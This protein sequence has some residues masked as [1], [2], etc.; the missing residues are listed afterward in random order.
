LFAG[1]FNDTYEV[2][3]PQAPILVRAQVAGSFV[4][5]RPLNIEQIARTT[6]ELYSAEA[7]HIW[8]T[9]V[10]STIVGGR[11]QLG[12]FRVRNLH[13]NPADLAGIFPD[14]PVPQ[15]LD[16][17]FERWSVYGYQSWQVFEPLLLVGGVSYDWL[18]FPENFRS[19]PM[20]DRQEEVERVLPK[21]GLIWTPAKYTTVRG[22]Y[23]RSLAGASLD[24]SIRLEPTQVAGFNQA[25]RSIIPE[26]VAGANAGARFETYDVSLEQRIGTRTYLGMDGEILYSKVPR[27]V[28]AYTLDTDV[29]DF[30]F[31]TGLRERLGFRER[32]LAFTIDQLLGNE[33][34]LGGRYRLSQAQLNGR[35]PEVT[36]TTTVFP[37]FIARPRVEAVL[38]QLNLHTIY[39]HPSGCFAQFQAHWSFQRNHGDT[40]ARPGDDFWHFD[41]F[42]G[43]RFPRRQ[44]QITVGVLN[45]ADRDYRLGPLNA[46]SERPRER[47]F[48]ARLQLNF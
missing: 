31:P 15:A 26:S 4:A 22:A 19:G 9:P 23:T 1:R 28:G 25:F 27:R 20:S 46:S 34:T 37:P 39:N 35:F 2:R 3:D 43:F 40:P 32:S 17:D 36:E 48:V 10:W 21:A 44:A 24:Q 6:F 45:L 41:I 29:S 11:I 16:L 30:V 5:L 14:P 47:T 33:W 42:A 7:Q 8:Q 12:D 18:R 13:F 38:H